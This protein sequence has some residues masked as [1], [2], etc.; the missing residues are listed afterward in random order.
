MKLDYIEIGTSDFDALVEKH[1]GNGISIEPLKF[2]LDALPKKENNIKI[3]AA[4]S[5]FIGKIKVYYIH[6]NDIINYNLPS[7]VR[8]C[9]SISEPHPQIINLLKSS[10]IRCKRY[11]R[12]IIFKENFEI[13]RISFIGN[14]E[15]RGFTIDGNKKIL[16]GNWVISNTI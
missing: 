14:D 9:N 3:N 5:N 12:F 7:W 10:G 8:G 2:Y 11:N 16:L 15:Y 6:P 13:F 4:V 1:E